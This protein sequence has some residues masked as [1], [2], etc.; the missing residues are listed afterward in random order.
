MATRWLVENPL[1]PG[2]PVEGRLQ[3][4]FDYDA[5]DALVAA[6]R[7]VKPELEAVT[8]STEPGYTAA[9]VGR[10]PNPAD[11]RT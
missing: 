3:D 4:P 7:R 10:Q 5:E 1:E 11:P 9:Y 2:G 8:W 6:W